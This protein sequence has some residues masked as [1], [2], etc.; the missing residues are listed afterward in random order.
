MGVAHDTRRSA[1]TYP[2][3]VLLAMNPRPVVTLSVLAFLIALRTVCALDDT[4]ASSFRVTTDHFS[5]IRGGV[6]IHISLESTMSMW[7]VN[8]ARTRAVVW[9][10]DWS[11]VQLGDPPVSRVYL[12]DLVGDKIVDQFTVTSGPYEAVFSKDQKL[13]RVDHTVLDQASGSRIGMTEDVYFEVESCP[14]FAGK[15][16]D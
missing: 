11:K 3:I 16:S 10:R 7:R 12:I 5:Y 9:G 14:A 13:A 4:F 1:E 15:R 6:D 8:C 2:S